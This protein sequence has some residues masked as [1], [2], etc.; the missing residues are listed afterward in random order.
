M[1]HAWNSFLKLNNHLWIEF[2]VT[3]QDII[4]SV[5]NDELFGCIKCDIKVSDSSKTKFEEMTPI[6]KNV[7][8]S[9]DDIGDFVQEY[10]EEHNIMTSPRRSLI[11]SMFGEKTLLATPLLKWYLTNGLEVTR[12]YQAIEYTPKT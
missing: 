6:F 9:V 11:G 7:T 1:I 8:I 2:H 4:S 5:I 10:A 3:L 12:I